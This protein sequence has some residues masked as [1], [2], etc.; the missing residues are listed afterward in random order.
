MHAYMMSND[1]GSL[2]AAVNKL[3]EVTEEHIQGPYAPMV[4]GTPLTVAGTKAVRKHVARNP[5][6]AKLMKEATD[7]HMTIWGMADKDPDCERLMELH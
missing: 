7:F 3:V 2:P 6:A 5:E 4:L 1:K